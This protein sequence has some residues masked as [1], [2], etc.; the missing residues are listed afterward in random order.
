MTKF[1]RVRKWYKLGLWDVDRVKNVVKMGCITTEE[2]L[3]IVGQIY[4]AE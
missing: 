3:S 4:I 2:Y 1:E